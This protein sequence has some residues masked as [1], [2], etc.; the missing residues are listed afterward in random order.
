VG[1]EL[2]H[3]TKEGLQ[4][5]SSRFIKVPD[6][7]SD[8]K[9]VVIETVFIKDRER[10]SSLKKRSSGWLKTGVHKPTGSGAVLIRMNVG[11]RR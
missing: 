10:P 3:S 7:E 1:E 2:P 5:N 8:R 6:S 4:G 9:K 11:V